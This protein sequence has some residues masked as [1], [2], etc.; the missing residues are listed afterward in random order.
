MANHIYFNVAARRKA[1][2]GDNAP[3]FDANIIEKLKEHNLPFKAVGKS[4]DVVMAIESRVEWRR[5]HVMEG[6][7]ITNEDIEKLVEFLPVGTILRLSHRVECHS[8]V[9]DVYEIKTKKG[10]PK[11]TKLYTIDYD[12]DMYDEDLYTPEDFKEEHVWTLSEEEKEAEIVRDSIRA[13][14]DILSKD[15]IEEEFRKFAEEQF[16]F[17]KRRDRM[18]KNK[19]SQSEKLP[20]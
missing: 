14:T 17:Q 8:A 10:E 4:E 16:Y 5:S 11:L 9:E 1:T 15:D 12:M 18:N 3:A 13:L 20:F 19:H 7:D 2:K 6:I